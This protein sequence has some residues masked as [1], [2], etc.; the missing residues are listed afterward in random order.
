M[1]WKITTPAELHNWYLEATKK[2]HPLSYNPKAQKKYNQLTEEQKFIDQYIASKL[3]NRIKEFY[4]Y[5]WG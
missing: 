3:N 1:T 2:I 5:Q 4:K